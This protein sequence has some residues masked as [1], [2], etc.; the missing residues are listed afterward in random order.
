MMEI[1]DL[2]TENPNILNKSTTLRNPDTK[3]NILAE[4][5]VAAISEDQ[6]QSMEEITSNYPIKRNK[7]I[8]E[9]LTPRRRSARL[10]ER[11]N[12]QSQSDSEQ[13]LPTPKVKENINAKTNMTI[14]YYDISRSLYSQ[15]F[16]FSNFSH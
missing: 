12:N 14:N 10:T 11:L 3:G 7:R 8:T 1:S 16:P 4:K 2:H 13:D 5:P 6:I 9:L 15:R